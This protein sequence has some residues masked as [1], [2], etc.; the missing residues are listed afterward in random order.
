MKKIFK[1]L[2]ITAA[3]AATPSFSEELGNRNQAIRDYTLH[4]CTTIQQQDDK[5]PSW[6]PRKCPE[7]TELLREFNTVCAAEILETNSEQCH[8]LRDSQKIFQCAE[9]I[10]S[11][12]QYSPC[13]PDITKG[14][15]KT[16]FPSVLLS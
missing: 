12:G 5:G 4:H 11:E 2:T 15:R 6:N 10:M 14:D 1:I 3:G 9:R 8:V 13:W 16:D 7:L